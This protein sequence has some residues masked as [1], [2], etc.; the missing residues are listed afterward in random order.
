MVKDMAMCWYIMFIVLVLRLIYNNVLLLNLVL[1][2]NMKMSLL[3]VL[4][5]R[6]LL[7]NINNFTLYKT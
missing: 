2:L 7:H 1:A 3:S 4:V 5:S 6:I